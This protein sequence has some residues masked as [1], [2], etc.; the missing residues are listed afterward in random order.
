MNLR[1]VKW[2][3]CVL[4]AACGSEPDPVSTD[5]PPSVP[6][7]TPPDF[8]P[9]T[10]PKLAFVPIQ[11]GVSRATDFEFVPGTADELVVITQPGRVQR[12]RIRGNSATALGAGAISVFDEAGCGL[13]SMAFDPEFTSNGYVYFGRCRDTLT[14]TLSRYDMTALATLEA[15]EAEI[16]SVTVESLPPEQWHRWGSLGFEPDGETMWALHGDMF[17]RELAQDVTTRHGSLLRFVPNRESGGSGYTTVEGNAADTLRDADPTV[18]SYGLR[19][20]WRGYRDS[21]GRFWVGD[22]GLETTEEVDLISEPAQNLGWPR[23]EGACQDDCASLTDPLLSFGR[24]SEEPY[25]IEDPDTEPAT[26]RAVWVGAG[27]EAPSVDR[28]YGLLDGLVLY[29]DF[30]T[31]W[32]RG[33]QVD[34]DGAVTTDRL[35]GHLTEVTSVKLGP[36]GYLYLLTLGGALYRAEQVLD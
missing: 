30:F 1:V 31:G 3:G 36:D 18:Y 5:M 20:P 23:A 32:V 25:V 4:L 19:S 24:S 21:S 17:V 9:P 27:Y 2:L 7:V 22:V 10:E 6:T 12:T 28:Y 8:E 11:L 26:K 16:M 15:S 35:L 14:S 13:L 29:G 33:V 34:D